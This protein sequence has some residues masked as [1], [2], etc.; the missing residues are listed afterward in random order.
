M[1]SRLSVYQKFNFCNTAARHCPKQLRQLPQ[2]AVLFALGYSAAAAFAAASRFSIFFWLMREYTMTPT[3]IT[4][5]LM[6]I[7]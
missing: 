4:K 2:D 7:G 6:A 5:K 3:A 1:I